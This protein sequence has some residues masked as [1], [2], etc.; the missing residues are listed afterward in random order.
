MNK[1]SYPFIQC[2]H[3]KRIFNEYIGEC[4]LVECGHCEA[5]LTRKASRNALKCRLESKA[6]EYCMFV[7]LTYDQQNV[8]LMQVMPS[9]RATD[10]FSDVVE[11][12]PRLA[13][14]EILGSVD[15]DSYRSRQLRKKCNTFN[16]FPHLSKR[17]LQLFIKRLRKY[18]SKVSD[19]KIRY[20]AV[21]EYGPIHFRPHYHL[22]LWYSSGQIHEIIKQAILSCW[23]FGRVDSQKSRGDCSKYVAKYVVGNCNL[24][25]IFKLR[26]IA[27][28]ALHS[29]H[30]GE[31]ILKKEKEA[32]YEMSARDFN[33][34]SVCFN[35]GTKEFVLWRSL[36]TYY[37]PK[38][39]GYSV[40]NDEQLYY[41]YRLYHETSNWT[42]KTCVASQA[43][44]I[45]STIFG[46]YRT[47]GEAGLCEQLHSDPQ[48]ND[49]LKHFV[50]SC[51]INGFLE[52]KYDVYFTRIYNEL[53][54]SKHFLMF[55]CDG[56]LSPE[57]SYKMIARIKEYWN[58]CDMLNLY[59]Q[60]ES[61]ET[62]DFTDE[63]DYQFYYMT[64]AWKKEIS[65]TTF[66]RQ[67]LS[68]AKKRAVDSIKHKKLND[69]NKIFIY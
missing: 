62:L 26:N 13:E 29:Y 45:L 6:H 61:Q 51:E 46:V 22:L 1:E 67:F 41:V 24:P 37:F 44:Y 14:G 65:E 57:K 2:L 19:E 47:F 32:V 69:L 12:T 38:C 43:R 58:E 33:Q 3:P 49:L 15:I 59:S 68:D 66:Y 11:C 48:V 23:R 36:K 5:C 10:Y 63:E 39:K 56:D 53:R 18:L 27:P 20:Y 16:L 34:R 60:L 50:S 9:S 28:F 4:V 31:S 17:D 7:T 25:R 8:P 55:V 42:K 52:A 35:D 64:K 40:F 30:L 54:L 21:G